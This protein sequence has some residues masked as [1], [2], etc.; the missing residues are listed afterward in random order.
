MNR[1]RFTWDYG[2]AVTFSNVEVLRVALLC[3]VTHNPIK[4]ALLNV[5]DVLP[6][7]IQFTPSEDLYPV[8]VLPT[9]SIRTQY[10]AASPSL[11]ETRPEPPP[12]LFRYCSEVP[13]EGVM[14]SMANLL[15]GLSDSRIIT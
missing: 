3:A 8:K 11:P 15:F 2:N 14:I 1:I 4:A 6:T 9:R 5:M 13:L 12:V 10:G 7:W